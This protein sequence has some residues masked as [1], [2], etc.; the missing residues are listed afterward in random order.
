[1]LSVKLVWSQ[2]LEQ[3]AVRNHRVIWHLNRIQSILVVC[4]ELNGPWL[5]AVS[6]LKAIHMINI[7]R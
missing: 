2:V 5:R 4:W 3:L 6:V 7:L 1:M